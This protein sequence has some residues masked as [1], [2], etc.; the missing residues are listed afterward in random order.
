MYKDRGRDLREGLLGPWRPSSRSPSQSSAPHWADL[1]LRDQM[2]SHSSFDMV[3]SCKP[4]KQKE[5][6]RKSPGPMLQ[7]PNQLRATRSVTNTSETLRGI[8]KTQMYTLW[9][10]NSKSST[11]QYPES[12][13]PL[14]PICTPLSDWSWFPPVGYL[15]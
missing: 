12:Q 2:S 11:K 10:S 14:D 3:H 1:S 6:P 8:L 4:G 9:A 15:W 13:P 7:N 5:L